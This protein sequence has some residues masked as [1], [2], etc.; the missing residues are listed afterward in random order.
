MPVPDQHK[1]FLARAIELAV[2]GMHANKGGPFGAVIVKDGVIIAE[3]SN[4]VRRLHLHVQ[5]REGHVEQGRN[6]ACRDRGDS[7][8]VRCAGHSRSERVHV[9]HVVLAV[10]HVS[11]ATGYRI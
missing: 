3:A 2:E 5:R 1:R 6:V 4:E 9:V 10:S 7:S 8:S 11:V